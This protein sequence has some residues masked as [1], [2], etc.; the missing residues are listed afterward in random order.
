MTERAEHLENNKR[1][2]KRLGKAEQVLLEG[3]DILDGATGMIH[4]RRMGQQTARAGVVVTTDRRVILFTTKLGG[5]DVQDF[6]YGLLTSVDHKKGVMYGDL[7][8]NAAGDRAHVK[9][10]PR[11]DIERLAQSIRD[12]MALAR[13]PEAGQAAVTSEPAAASDPHEELRKLAALRDD[14][15]ITEDDFQTK[16][17]QLLG[18]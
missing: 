11:G 4:V 17:R 10:I 9:Q 15:I 3:E 14:G 16:K 2:R 1:L 5:Y 12:R 13:R 18:I 8:L 7:H 6:A